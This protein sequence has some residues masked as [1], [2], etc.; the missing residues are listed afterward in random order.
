MGMN[1]IDCVDRCHYPKNAEDKDEFGCQ[2]SKPSAFATTAICWTLG[3]PPPLTLSCVAHIYSVHKASH[4]N[5]EI[6]AGAAS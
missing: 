1:P 6:A 3:P 5:C 2:L 4:A